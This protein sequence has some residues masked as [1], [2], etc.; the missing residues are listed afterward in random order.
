ML[1]PAGGF[2][3]FVVVLL[4]FSILGNIAA[5]FYSITL[6][7]Q[8]LIPYLVRVPRFVFSILMLAVVI[9][10]SVVA[11]RSFFDSLQNFIG[12]IGYWSAAFVAIIIVEHL[13][14]RRRCADPY[15]IDSWDVAAELPTGIAALAAGALSFALIIP[16][17]SEVWYT[18]PLAETTGDIGFEVAF[19][20]SAVL[21]LP[22]RA[23]EV[24][25][26]GRI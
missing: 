13:V 4:A 2:G 21:Y 26:L 22:F 16:C 14:F 15:P 9:P 7:F 17:M 23:L 12:V 20:L 6:N 3:Q 25:I 11:A 5:S 10:V 8:I 18:G 19:V 24:K 1:S